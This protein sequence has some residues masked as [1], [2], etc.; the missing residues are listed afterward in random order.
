[1]LSG[2]FTYHNRL[3]M[4][5]PTSPVLSN[6]TT[7]AL[8]GQLE[9]YTHS[10]GI[11]Y[12]RYVDDLTFSSKN[13][14][15][16][17]DFEVIYDFIHRNGFQVNEKKFK[18]FGPHEMKE[19]TGLLLMDN[20]VQLPNGYLEQINEEINRLKNTLIVEQRF[21]TGMSM[22]KLK[23]LKQEIQ[24]KISFSAM[25]IGKTDHRVQELV[26]KYNVAI[27]PPENFESFGWL[28]IPYT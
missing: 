15:S 9:N 10:A 16:P 12:T 25:V 14:F 8:D 17:F 4:G 24:G 19:I 23:L 28:D 3:P 26:D 20:Q 22:R 27:D 2:L 13:E 6:S 5:S 11:T 1:M 18:K 21:K 7:I